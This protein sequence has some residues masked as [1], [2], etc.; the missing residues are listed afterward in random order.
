ML[1]KTDKLIIDESELKSFCDECKINSKKI[2]VATGVFDILHP[3]HLK[4]LESAREQGD[5]LIVGMNNDENVRKSKGKNRPIQNEYDRAYLVAGF[6]CVS[7]VHIFSVGT[8]FF[9]LVQPDVL[10]MSASGGIAVENRKEHFSM[11]EENGGEVVV[12]DAFSMLH[13][14]EIIEKIKR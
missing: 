10:I 2:V 9:R 8:D 13:S 1:L 14:S 11:I 7:R 3:G 6:E 4:F 12:F 5:I